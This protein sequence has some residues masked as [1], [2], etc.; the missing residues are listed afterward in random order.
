MTEEIPLSRVAE[1]LA[2]MRFLRRDIGRLYDR[3][4]PLEERLREVELTGARDAGAE[5]SRQRGETRRVAI[6]AGGIS[7]LVSAGGAWLSAHLGR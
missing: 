2:E 1:L 4:G 7:A 6:L 3:L 5:A